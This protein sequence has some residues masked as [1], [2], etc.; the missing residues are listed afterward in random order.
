VEREVQGA[1]ERTKSR[2]HGKFFEEGYEETNF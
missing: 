2:D 1:V